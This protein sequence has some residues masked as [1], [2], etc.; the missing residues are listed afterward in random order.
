VQPGSGLGEAS[1]VCDGD[2]VLKLMQLHND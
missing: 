2:Q 1:L